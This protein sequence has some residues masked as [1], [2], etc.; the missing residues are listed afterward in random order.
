MRRASSSV[1]ARSLSSPRSWCDEGRRVARVG[2]Q[3]HDLAALGVG[4]DEQGAPG[5]GATR[6]AGLAGEPRDLLGVDDVAREED[7]AAH[8]GH[9]QQLL[10]L[11]VA[12]DLGPREAH[13]Q[14]R[15]RGRAARGRR[16]ARGA[17]E[18]DWQAATRRAA[19]TRRGQPRPGASSHARSARAA[20]TSR[21]TRAGSTGL[22]DAPVALEPGPHDHP[23]RDREQLGHRLRAD[24]AAHEDRGPRA[25]RRAPA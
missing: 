4:G 17:G 12:E 6:V 14:E 7:D 3:A 21:R 24:A 23:V 2:S 22:L 5:A 20:S 19:R 9:A 16:E 15:R 8:A 1:R 11:A 10:E 18:A 13:E 25:P